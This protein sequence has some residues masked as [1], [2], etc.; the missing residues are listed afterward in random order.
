MRGCCW[1]GSSWSCADPRRQEPASLSGGA[2]RR[3]AGESGLVARGG[4]AMDEA[5]R[6]HLV[7]HRDRRAQ[8]ILDALRIAAVDSRANITERATEPGTKL[9]VVFPPLYVLTMRF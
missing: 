8:R 6:R 4:V 3:A 7:D 2:L 1:S 5:L 9:T